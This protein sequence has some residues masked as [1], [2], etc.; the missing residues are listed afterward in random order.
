MNRREFNT[1]LSLGSVAKIASPQSTPPVAGR[2]G[3]WYESL[4]TGVHLDYHFPEWDPYI[5]SKADGADMIRKIAA[6]KAEM[7]VVYSKCH[8]GNAYYN[9]A[10]GHKHLNLGE[11]DLL[12]EWVTEARRQKLTVLA[13][14]SVDR[15]AWAGQQHPS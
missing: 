8:Y 11:K 3:K 7:V 15:D 5:L 1:L 4:V 14:Y 6:T 9:T 12:R 10:V 13:Y 2:T